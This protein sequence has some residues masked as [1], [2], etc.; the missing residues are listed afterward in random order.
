MGRGQNKQEGGGGGGGEKQRKLAPLF[1][2]SLIPRGSILDD[3]LEEKR[4]LLAV[5]LALDNKSET[6][7]TNMKLRGQVDLC[8]L[9]MVW[10]WNQV[11][12]AESV[13]LCVE[14]PR[15]GLWGNI[16]E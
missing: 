5:Y 7:K 4:R 16:P 9:T 13:L 15:S 11:A 14:C 12:S 1:A 8:E 3:L 6:D 10:C 2:R